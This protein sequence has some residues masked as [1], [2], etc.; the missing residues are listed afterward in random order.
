MI[1]LL[2]LVFGLIAL[3]KGEFKITQNRRVKD[4]R[5]LGCLMLFGAAISFLTGGQGWLIVLG[6]LVLAIIVG[7][8]VSEEIVETKA[9]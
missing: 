3:V 2:L 7:L 8:A 9:H 1:D 5:G 6:V 4:G